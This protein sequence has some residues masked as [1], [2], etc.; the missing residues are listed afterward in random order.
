MVAMQLS[1]HAH[2]EQ[3]LKFQSYELVK[4]RTCYELIIQEE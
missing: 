3:V 4:K 1:E 2:G